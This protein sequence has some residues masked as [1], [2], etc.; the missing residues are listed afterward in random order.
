MKESDYFSKDI[1]DRMKAL[2]E[3]K[4]WTL[5]QKKASLIRASIITKSGKLTS[6][7]K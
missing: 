6:H 3:V 5:E 7:Y 2:E 4:E 1:A